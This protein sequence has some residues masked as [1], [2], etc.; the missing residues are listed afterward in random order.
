M[1]RQLVVSCGF[2]VLLASSVALAGDFGPWTT[3]VNLGPAVNSS[4][5]DSGPGLSKN[6]LSLYFHS[7]RPGLG[8]N[9]L[10]VSHRASK[11]EPWQP[12]VM[13]PAPINSPFADVVPNLSRDE[14]LLF[15]ASTRA[16]GNNNLNSF[17]LY[18]SRRV[19]THDDFA[20]EAPVP[21]TELNSNQLDAGPAYFENEG[22]RPQLYFASSRA[23]SQDIYRSELQED[24]TWAAPIPVSELNS[25][26]DDAR[27]AIRHDGLE[28]FFNSTR[29]GNQDLY[30]SRRNSVSEAWSAPVNL[31]AVVNSAAADVQ[32]AISSDGTALYFG[33]ARPNGVGSTDLWVT[34]RS[35]RGGN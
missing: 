16:S 22:G 5:A 9:D 19:H 14:H 25:P 3:P 33:S 27:P 7:G 17:D 15:F 4:F 10:Y 31:G 11:G 30:V 6:G 29:D 26:A 32:S 21:I 2:I 23:G 1:Q 35:K 24:G 12:P 18:V 20:W 13:L 34:T 8:S 28:I